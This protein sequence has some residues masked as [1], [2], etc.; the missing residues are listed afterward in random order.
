MV[1]GR[2]A[3]RRSMSST[4]DSR[5]RAIGIVVSRSRTCGSMPSSAEASGAGAAVSARSRSRSSRTRSSGVGWSKTSV[6]G[7]ASAVAAPI[8]LRR[9]TAVRE[10]KPMSLKARVGSTEA[11][12]EW[13][14][15][16]ATWART[17]SSSSWSCS[18]AVRAASRAVRFSAVPDAS[19]A[20]ALRLRAAGTRSR[21]TPARWSACSAR[22]AGRNAT[23]TATGSLTRRAA[24]SRARAWSPG[25]AGKPWRRMRASSARD[26]VPPMPASVSHMPQARDTAG[27][28]WARRA[29]A[30]ASR[31]ALAAAYAACPAEP[32]TPAMDEYSTKAS[33]W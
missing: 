32:M 27:S 4:P 24:S 29:V 11:G 21:R 6:A 7:R 30:S 16:A 26:R 3:S 22:A 33:R 28:P 5:S 9:S 8:R 2:S 19:R 1:A 15:T 12:E 23:G 18:G 13:P 20:A 10:S 17:R 31:A 14:S 25:R